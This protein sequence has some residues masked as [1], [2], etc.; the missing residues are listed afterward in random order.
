MDNSKHLTEVWSGQ[1]QP[2]ASGKNCSQN[3]TCPERPTSGSKDDHLMASS[4]TGE[5]LSSQRNTNT[6]HSLAPL[7]AP[8]LR[9]MECLLS[10]C[11]YLL[12]PV[13]IQVNKRSLAEPLVAWV[14]PLG[15][16]TWQR[17]VSYC[18]QTISKASHNVF[19]SGNSRQHL[20]SSHEPLLC[21]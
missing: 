18:Y 9:N 10:L 19:S 15:K 14:C 4:A 2:S 8:V 6:L 17:P 3:D 11:S 16:C 20:P 12:G 1:H 21:S 5:L 7:G 13:F